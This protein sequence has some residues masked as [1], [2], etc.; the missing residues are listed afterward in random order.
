MW[1]RIVLKVAGIKILKSDIAV[2]FRNLFVK[3]SVIHIQSIR[4]GPDRA[5]P[6][7]FTPSQLLLLQLLCVFETLYSSAI[8]LHFRSGIKKES[9]SL[10][11]LGP[12]LGKYQISAF[13]L[14][15]TLQKD[16]KHCE[17]SIHGIF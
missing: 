3:D 8:V 5:Y 16:K 13:N 1:I 2:K 6:L 11:Y 10:L 4:I 14:Y 7:H 15:L 9:V 12:I 17:L